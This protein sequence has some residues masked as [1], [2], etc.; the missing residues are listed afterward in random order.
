MRR[1]ARRADNPPCGHGGGT[2]T[3]GNGSD[4]GRR[5]WQC[6]GCGRSFTATTG[7]PVWGLKTPAA[8]VARALLCVLRRGSLR[9][10]E[11]QTGHKYETIGRWLRRAGGHAE[12]LTAALVHE[13]HLSEVEI[14]EFWSFVRRKGAQ[15]GSGRRGVS[16]G[17]A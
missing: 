17:A 8:E 16:V 9:A 10:A 2:D 13:I 14:D 6:H 1:R 3:V 11:E 5:K 4:R 12:A 15:P 7:T